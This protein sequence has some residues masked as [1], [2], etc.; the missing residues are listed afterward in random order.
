MTR[1]REDIPGNAGGEGPEQVE[2]IEAIGGVAIGTKPALGGVDGDGRL[3][4]G[5]LAGLSMWGAIF[6]LAWPILVE[7]FLQSLVG[8]VDTKLATSLSESATDSIGGAAYFLWFLSLIGMAV[9]VGATAIVSRSIGKGRQAVANA[10]TSQAVLLAAAAG[11]AVA[12]LVFAMAPEIGRMLQMTEEASEGLVTY[13]RICAVGVPAL[14][15]MVAGSACCRGA[16]DA[17]RPLATVAIVNVVNIFVSWFLSGVDLT[18]ARIDESGEAVVQT[19][20]RNPSPFD[21]GIEGIAL[22]TL[23]AWLSG[24]LIIGWWLF[25]GTCGVKVTRRRLRPHR[26]TMG[27]LIGVG[28]PNFVETFGMWF[29]NFVV[30]LMVGWMS[31]PGYLGTHI[32]AVRI[33]A[34]SFMP[35]FA[36]GLAASTLAGQYL[37]AGAPGL[38]KTAMLRC[39]LIACG[40]M[41]LLGAVFLL[42]PTTIV[43]W[44]SEQPVHLEM[45]PKLIQIAGAIQIPFGVMMVL[46]TGMRGAGDTRMMMMITWVAT[47]AIRLPLAYVLSGVDIYLPEWVGGGVILNPSPWS[48][49]LVGLWFGLCGELVIRSLLFTAR[50]LHGGWMKVSV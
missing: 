18:R 35:G 38:A 39:T 34:F 31:V 4:S 26:V 9:G 14:G 43:G 25:R 22:G 1:E 33:E 11:A 5:K 27:R 7:S 23:A 16:G 36:M 28:T 12:S 21:L 15:V 13:L 19:L 10:A 41:G 17:K 29:G 50:F 47:Y 24:G 3:I 37:G 42:I 44:F 2:A 30:I 20:L 45:A 32:V 6:V 46:R 40:L 48:Y 49:G 8:L